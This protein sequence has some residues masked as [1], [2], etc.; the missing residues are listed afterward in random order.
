MEKSYLW[1]NTWGLVSAIERNMK[2]RFLFLYLLA[3]ILF[4]SSSDR[5]F[6]APEGRSADLLVLGQK[7]LLS[8]SVAALQVIASDGAS[9][10]PLAG[11]PVMISFLP[12]KGR[13]R[14]RL[15][16]GLT[17]AHGTLDA[18][19]DVPPYLEG[20]GTLFV[21][22]G[23]EEPSLEIE[24]SVTVKKRIKLC[25]ATDRDA[26][27]PGQLVHLRCMGLFLPDL[28]PSEAL[29]TA[30]EIRDPKNNIV[31]RKNGKASKYGIFSADF[32]LAGELNLGEYRVRASMGKDSRE[33]T[34]M[35][36]RLSLPRFR[37]ELSTQK[38]YYLPAETIR[39]QVRAE[40]FF[41]K[42]VS[43]GRVGVKLYNPDENGG[44]EAM[45]SG[46]T[47]AHGFYR[48]ELK[49]PG[50]SSNWFPERGR[51][52][53]TLEA[54]VTDGEEHAVKRHS[55]VYTAREAIGIDLIPESGKLRTGL[56]NRIYCV[57]S[58]PDGSPASTR[59]E[60][61]AEGKKN[62]IISDQ[63]GFAE[64]RVVPG[65]PAKSE[66]ILEAR[67]D[68]GNTGRTVYSGVKD[69]G[70]SLI[71][72]L[73]RPVFRAGEPLSGEVVSGPGRKFVYL[74]LV[75]DGQTVNIASMALKNGRGAFS[76]DTTSRMRG[77]F[78]V[79]ALGIGKNGEIAR[80]SR[81]VLILPKD[82]LK[83]E[84]RTHR[85]MYI[86]GST[87]KLNFQVR[88]AAG[89]PV[90]AA[91]GIDIS[92]E[93]GVSGEEAGFGREWDS[94]FLDDELPDFE[95]GIHGLGARDLFKGQP[96]KDSGEEN[97][98]RTIM[99]GIPGKDPFSLVMDSRT[100]RIRKTAL[101]LELISEALSRYRE[102][103]HTLPSKGRQSELISGGFIAKENLIDPWGNPYEFR[104]T[105]GFPEVFSRGPDGLAQT[106]DDL[107]RKAVY[108]LER[109]FSSGG[110]GRA[111]TESDG[112]G[113]AVHATRTYDDCSESIYYDPQVLTNRD[114]FATR[115]IQLPTAIGTYRI[116]GFANSLGGET[117]QNT[118]S[119]RVFQDFLME[120]DLPRTL[121]SGD[122]ISL[123]AAL[124]NY[125]KTP[126]RVE[127]ELDFSQSW[128][129][130]MDRGYKAV[131]LAP[132]EVRVIY[133]RIKAVEPGWHKISVK[134]QGSRTADAASR[135]IEVLPDGK[136]VKLCRSGKLQKK[137]RTLIDIPGE[138]VSGT[139]RIQVA[140]F[141]GIISEVMEILDG[142]GR[143]P[144]GSFDQAAAAVYPDI[145]IMEYFLRTGKLTRDFRMKAEERL[146]AAYQ[147]LL[148]CEVRGGGFSRFGGSPADG[149]M[150]AFGL[151]VLKD[152]SAVYDI[153]TAVIGRARRWLLGRQERDG[154]WNPDE[155]CDI[156]FRNDNDADES[157]LQATA[158][159][160]WCLLESGFRDEKVE[161]ALGYV[162]THISDARE[163]CA[164]AL[165]AN[166]LAAD[167]PE[168]PVAGK[169]L[170]RLVSLG[171]EERG[172]AWL[173][174]PSGK[175][176]IPPGNASAI[177]T[178]ALALMALLRVGGYENLARKAA[179]WL[180]GMK[181]P[182]GDWYTAQAGALSAK[183]LI[184][185][186]EKDFR[187][188]R[189]KISIEVN[190][191][192][193][194]TCSLAPEDYDVFRMFDF[195]PET[196]NGEN[197]VEINF[198][199]TG[200]CFFRAAGRYSVPWSRAGDDNRKDFLGFNVSYDRTA[201]ALNE[202]ATCRVSIVNPL[203]RP[204]SLIIAE[205]GVPPG[206]EV[207]TSDL[208]EMIKYGIIAKYS[209]SDRQVI[210]CLG[211]MRPQEKIDFKYRLRARFPVKA[212]SPQSRAYESREP[213]MDSIVRPQMME[214]NEKP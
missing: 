10:E 30:V 37:V 136:E 1:P 9:N 70:D 190:G 20:K 200:E 189:G 213:E 80:D 42:P 208:E 8:G 142:I 172:L 58:Y 29:N 13:E 59:I 62:S 54:I 112:S 76:F 111:E 63:G 201:L 144:R 48:F 143:L 171:K 73:D 162:S 119:L 158:F 153:D 44:K 105:G 188:A 178:S 151:M 121:T 5:G 165:C 185:S 183:A 3:A 191:R 134:V 50:Y 94:L 174:V 64:F 85:P 180:A 211:K 113:T 187:T 49:L 129:K 124:Y 32:Q 79:H 74:D 61:Q 161:R 107:D 128:F 39:G 99:S 207:Q 81:L 127:L 83:V 102:K 148:S 194:E 95:Y 146:N 34:F 192:G 117:G 206:F 126:Q 46:R 181:S 65:S 18:R 166:V 7:E 184:L 155:A 149:I 43:G 25:L 68:R 100:L 116:R 164:L 157:R 163:P 78:S 90:Q 2:T 168:N 67:D 150:T 106:E 92:G 51:G 177:N 135:E 212:W 35:V 154:S 156:G 159:I 147:E 141:P 14:H 11:V 145:L 104:E 114:G 210:V 214:I 204:R 15:Y 160:A 179:S 195:G 19:F 12:E 55:A 122:E 21:S 193:E 131:T 56:E 38:P 84:I 130:L 88:D 52:K 198:D 17:D 53:I 75:H 72:R 97:L 6:G 87:A 123:P 4:M 203:K 41:G 139:G 33:R 205:L 115:E 197:I 175:G 23:Q 186:Q 108:R 140:V 91:L 93:S 45:S 96:R 71:L 47:D 120:L 66:I 125:M 118:G 202:L 170:G 133:F 138:A 209:V 27:R 199:G 196:R 103:M 40:Y 137:A 60:I 36:R 69:A 31:F 182:D 132:N 82:E 22:A 167:N 28:I 86:P 169:A 16:R 110:A 176:I 98:A 109:D 89:R 152:M 77:A 24:A 26:Y 57:T 101:D 173:V